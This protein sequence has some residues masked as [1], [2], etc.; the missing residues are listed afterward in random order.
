MKQKKNNGKKRSGS[1]QLVEKAG[2]AMKHGFHLEASML[3]SLAM[4]RKL[5][6]LIVKLGD[7]R[8]GAGTS[9]EQ[10]VKRIKYLCLAPAG[11][12]RTPP[13]PVDL[14]DRIRGWKNQRNEIL[15][16]IP[17]VHVSPARLERLAGDGVKLYR[18][19]NRAAKSVKVIKPVPFLPVR[20]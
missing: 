20:E 1:R 12:E 19:L 8:P 3:L 10:S 7:R 17:E 11:V 14:I 9:L 4:E 15:K 5:K 16:D 18:E 2:L 13:V 6:K